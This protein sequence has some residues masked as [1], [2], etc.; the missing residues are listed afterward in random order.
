MQ[1]QLNK[2]Q[3]IHVSSSELELISY[4]KKQLKNFQVFLLQRI[5]DN[6]KC[7][8]WSW[9]EYTFSSLPMFKELLNSKPYLKQVVLSFPTVL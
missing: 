8:Y 4:S 9:Q 1:N 7:P 5:Y 6:E 3:Y 2:M